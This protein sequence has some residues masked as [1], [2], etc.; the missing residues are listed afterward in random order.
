MTTVL[1]SANTSASRIKIVGQWRRSSPQAIR[2]RLTPC[3]LLF[4]MCARNLSH[5]AVHDAIPVCH[6][7]VVYLPTYRSKFPLV[8]GKM[9]KLAPARAHDSKTLTARA[10]ETFERFD[11]QKLFPFGVQR[12]HSGQS[13]FGIEVNI[14]LLYHYIIIIYMI[15]IGLCRT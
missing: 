3:T 4:S 2:G 10:W 1:K 8:H 6:M 15:E 9:L 14:Y 7:R 13:C 11:E 5:T 12:K